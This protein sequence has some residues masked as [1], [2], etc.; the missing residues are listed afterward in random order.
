MVA[1]KQADRGRLNDRDI[2]AIL[3]EMDDARRAQQKGLAVDKGLL[4]HAINDKIETLNLCNR[5]LAIRPPSDRIAELQILQGMLTKAREA[6]DRC[7]RLDW[8]LALEVDR[9]AGRQCKP[10]TLEQWRSAGLP[11]PHVVGVENDKVLQTA[12]E[13]IDAMQV[14]VPSKNALEEVE[15]AQAGL[16]L[17][18]R[19]VEA[20]IATQIRRQTSL[21]TK[22]SPK[23]ADHAQYALILELVTVY[24]EQFRQRATRYRDGQCCAFLAAVLRRCEGGGQRSHLKPAGAYAKWREARLWQRSD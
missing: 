17:L 11:E 20:S 5:L 9:L 3:E 14:P 6:L 23:Q 13:I 12:L 4:K 8:A 22:N 1:K 7:K 24:E 10:P 15:R 16:G 2:E 19:L 18:L 21:R